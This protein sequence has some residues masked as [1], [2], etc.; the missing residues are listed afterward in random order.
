MQLEA[1]HSPATQL[2]NMSALVA[3]LVRS[4]VSQASADAF[5]SSVTM[6]S[7]VRRS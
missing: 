1:S 4:G 6:H 2:P 7:H 3:Q 5:G